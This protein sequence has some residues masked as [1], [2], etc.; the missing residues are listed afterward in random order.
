MLTI[1]D[2]TKRLNEKDSKLT[3]LE[4]HDSWFY[5]QEIEEK[6]FSEFTNAIA[7][8]EKLEYVL[9]PVPL[10][11]RKIG[12]EGFIAVLQALTKVAK[13]KK[14][15]FN[16]NLHFG[17]LY[18]EDFYLSKIDFKVYSEIVNLMKH[19]G[20]S[21]TFM[22]NL[23]G[24]LI[25]LDDVRFK[26]L[27]DTFS[28]LNRAPIDIGECLNSLNEARIRAVFNSF[29]NGNNFYIKIMCSQLQNLKDE[30]FDIFIATLANS[31]KPTI[32]HHSSD[33][34][35]SERFIKL[36]DSIQCFM[37]LGIYDDFSLF[38]ADCFNKMMHLLKT[39][40]VTSLHIEMGPGSGKAIV[41]KDNIAE[42]CK[43][44]EKSCSLSF[45]AFFILD[46]AKKEYIIPIINAI[47]NNTSITSLY[48]AR[49]IGTPSFKEYFIKLCEVVSIKTSISSLVLW[50]NN[51]VL[52]D[53]DEEC[54][55]ALKQAIQ[56][57]AS[58]TELP[59]L[60]LCPISYAAKEELAKQRLKTVQDIINPRISMATHALARCLKKREINSPLGK[61]LPQ[62]AIEKILTLYND[63]KKLQEHVMLKEFP[64]KT[65]KVPVKDE[66]RVGRKFE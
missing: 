19:G 38:K 57:N 27:I 53:V 39:N 5:S 50:S 47:A 52:A 9:V 48:S 65:P 33:K 36:C 59:G 6:S 1:A 54:F 8:S 14:S 58:I 3:S 11:L 12:N 49:S 24:L 7:K 43:V 44:L 46:E 56:Q 31:T 42:F 18:S 34:L 35:S 29:I 22:Y 15:A 62:V 20:Q 64:D 13:R 30:Y 51:Y 25:D 37:H 2:I 16:I 55:S 26:M 41:N 10:V 21:I 40:R 61:E 17:G 63:K 4:L 32:L 23:D 28:Y 60:D 45:L 66:P